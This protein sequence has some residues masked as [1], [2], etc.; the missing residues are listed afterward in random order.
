MIFVHDAASRARRPAHGS[1]SF[2]NLTVLPEGLN[3]YAARRLAGQPV[4]EVGE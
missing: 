1:L 2:L 3:V 4:L